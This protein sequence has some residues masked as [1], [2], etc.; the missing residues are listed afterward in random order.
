MCLN[1]SPQEVVQR[2]HEFEAGKLHSCIKAH[3]QTRTQ[4]HTPAHKESPQE[5]EQRGHE[6]EA[7]DLRPFIQVN[8]HTITHM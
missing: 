3:K 7:G 2:G 8:R 5:V 6:F 4:A 1:C